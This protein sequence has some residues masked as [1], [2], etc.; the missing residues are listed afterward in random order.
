MDSRGK[1][2]CVDGKDSGNRGAHCIEVLNCKEFTV[3]ET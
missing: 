1:V 2:C 3:A